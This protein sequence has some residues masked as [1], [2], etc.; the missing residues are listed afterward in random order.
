M[1]KSA[2]L[3]ER[4]PQDTIDVPGVGTL[5]L[6]GLNRWQAVKVQEAK[7]T[8]ASE[9]LVLLYGIVDP[10]LTADD[11]DQ[12][13]RVAPAGEIEPVARRIA[14]LSGMAGDAPKSGVPRVRG[15][16]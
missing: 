14:E 10:A 6:R 5:T 16:R 11:V 4:L 13:Y 1:D 9:K 2:L 3:S 12:W 8:E 15:K 7:G